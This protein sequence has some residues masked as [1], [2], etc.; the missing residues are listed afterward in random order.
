MRG[1]ESYELLDVGDGRRLERFGALVVDRP[2]PGASGRPSEPGVWSGADLRFERDGGWASVADVAP[3]AWPID[4]AG[5]TLELH[6]AAG[7]QVGVFP[8]QL[9]LLAWLRDRVSSGATSVLNLFAYTGLATLTAAEAG[10]TVAHVDASKP[11]VAWARR[12]AEL[13]GLADRPIRW[14]VDDALG[15]VRREARRGRRYDGVILDPPT[16]GHAGRATWRFQDD[17]PPLLEAVES[18]FEPGGFVLLTSHTPDFWSGALADALEDAFGRRR[19][20]ESGELTI[21]A[22]SGARLELGAYARF[23]H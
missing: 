11:A 22:R 5:L 20:I 4:L 9:A 21:E 7:G 15:F 2:A 17:L 16:Y 10:A 1:G 12:N 3:G 8:E 23:G 19:S 18:V 14:L 6:A 13:S